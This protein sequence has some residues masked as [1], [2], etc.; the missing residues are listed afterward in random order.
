MKTRVYIETTIP[1]YLAARPSRDLIQAA[2]QTLTREWW[3]ERRKGF[4]LFISQFV[5]DES[6]DGDSDAARRRLELL[7]ELPLLPID[8][9]V[10]ALAEWLV[11]EGLIPRKA[12]VDALHVAVATV[13][14]MDVLLTWNCRHLANAELLGG[15]RFA[16]QSQGWDMPVICTP[17]ELMGNDD[18]E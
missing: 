6:G 1:S 15:L 13:S 5:L 17:E 10:M 9:S 18:E 12:A 2:H 4:D 8:D 11:D 14:D 16:L 3:D 7:T